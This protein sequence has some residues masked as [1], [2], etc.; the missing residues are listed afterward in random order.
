MS[1]RKISLRAGAVVVLWALAVTVLSACAQSG[2]GSGAAV[3]ATAT[4]PRTISFSGRAWSVKF[5]GSESVGPGPMRFGNSSRNVDI[6]SQGALHMRIENAGGAWVGAE[7]ILTELLGYGTYTFTLE[8]I[9]DLDPNVVLGL[10]TWS[11]NPDEAHREIDIE[12]A[13][14]SDPDNLNAQCVVQPHELPENI[15]RFGLPETAA[16]STHS[17]TW[18]PDSVICET[19]LLAADGSAPQL[20]HHHEFTSGIPTPGEAQARMNLWLF[21]G[22]PPV[23]GQAAE[24]IVRE[25]RFT[26][27]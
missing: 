25:F 13:R 9:I 2:S 1:A 4:T 16:G 24:V 20:F 19:S 15:T 21:R 5:S 18:T 8:P 14:W 10:F 17:F 6:D 26:P 11:D 27:P 12:I 22:A 3:P 7:V 23:N